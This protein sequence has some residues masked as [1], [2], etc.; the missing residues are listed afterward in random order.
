M[1]EIKITKKFI[2]MKFLKKELHTLFFPFVCIHLVSRMYPLIHLFFF[3]KNKKERKGEKKQISSLKGG[4]HPQN[5]S[6]PSKPHPPIPKLQ[7]FY[8]K[9]TGMEEKEDKIENTS[10]NKQER[11]TGRERERESWRGM[12]NF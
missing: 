12:F 3:L 2:E 11:E 6:P 7:N 10:S 1:T 5:W 4:L 9:K 8:N